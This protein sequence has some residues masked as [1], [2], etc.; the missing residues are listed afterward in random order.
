M[1]PPAP[2]SKR[3]AESLLGE[4]IDAWLEAQVEAKQSLRAIA[5]NL[6]EATDGAAD[7]SPETIR[8]WMPKKAKAAS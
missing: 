8:N 4:P 6:F 3:L 7:F 2:L 5:R 1:V